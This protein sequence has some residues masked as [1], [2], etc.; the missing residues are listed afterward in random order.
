MFPSVLN[1]LGIWNIK[2]CKIICLNLLMLIC[3]FSPSLCSNMKQHTFLSIR[4]QLLSTQSVRQKLWG[5]CCLINC[6]YGVY[7]WVYPWVCNN[8]VVLVSVHNSAW[9]SPED[10][11]HR[12]CEPICQV[13][14]EK[15]QRTAYSCNFYGCF[16]DYILN[17]FSSKYIFVLLHWF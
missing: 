5:V 8:N 1:V 10:Q 13:H 2:Y 17:F 6:V 16:L 3:Q 7:V 14:I 15:S 12:Q 4:F 11:D 9:E